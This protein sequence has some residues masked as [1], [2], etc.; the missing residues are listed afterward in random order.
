MVALILQET[1]SVWRWREVVLVPYEVEGHPSPRCGAGKVLV[2]PRAG[3]LIAHWT[4]LPR[5]PAGPGK[6]IGVTAT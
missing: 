4:R 1:D 2:F 5:R 3:Q 6:L